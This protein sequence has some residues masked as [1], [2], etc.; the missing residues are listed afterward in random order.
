MPKKYFGHP[1]GKVQVWVKIRLRAVA[2]ST[3]GMLLEVT[4]NLIPTQ[5]REIFWEPQK[6]IIHS[7]FC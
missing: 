1:H 4:P 3:S 5:K 6:G 7:P 2:K